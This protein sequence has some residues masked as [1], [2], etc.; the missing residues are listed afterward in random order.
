MADMLFQTHSLVFLPTFPPDSPSCPGPEAT[1][2]FLK[3]FS[4]MVPGSGVLHL[5]FLRLSLSHLPQAESSMTTDVNILG[6]GFTRAR[7]P[8]FYPT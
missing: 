3:G 1:A 7:K 8:P 6:E 5:A 2:K 4:F